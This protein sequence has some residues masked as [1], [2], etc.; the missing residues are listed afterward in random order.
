MDTEKSYRLHDQWEIPFTPLDFHSLTIAQ[1]Y[2]EM[3][4][5]LQEIHSLFLIFQF[6][7]HQLQKEYTLMSDGAVFCGTRPADLEEDYIAINAHIRNI[8]SAGKTL[9]ESMECFIKTGY[10]PTADG[11]QE[12]YLQHSHEIYDN[13][14][15][16]R[17][18]IRMRDYAQ[19]GHVPVDCENHH[20]HFNL[21]HI[22]NKPHHNHNR[23]LA[24]QMQQATDEILEFYRDIPTLGLTNTLAEF[25]ASLLSI[26]QIF[27]QLV[28]RPFQT[29]ISDFQA[30]SAQYPENII[31]PPDSSARLF[32]Y[33]I[34]DGW[35]Q[36]CD[37]TDD[38]LTMLQNFQRE[39]H[40]VYNDYQTAWEDLR[41]GMIFIRYNDRH[42]LEVGTI[43]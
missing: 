18:L 41:K 12:T 33:E 34:T 27:W 32:L 35:V 1:R 30:I 38:S 7:L 5:H 11:Y 9:T 20:Y 43:S 16:Y 31:T 21:L 24:H 23:T 8:I 4:R 10:P 2:V 17:F 36:T 28:D 25:T 42:Q 19:H 26:Y 39:A 29:V 6:N 14:F 13:S 15:A 22:L 40:E 37:L 3:A